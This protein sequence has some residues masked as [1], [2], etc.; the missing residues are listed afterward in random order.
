MLSLDEA[1]LDDVFQYWKPPVRR[2]PPLLW[3]RLRRD[4][5]DFVTESGSQ[6]IPVYRWMHQQF[7]ALVRERYLG[8]PVEPEGAPR[9]LPPDM[10]VLLADKTKRLELML[11]SSDQEAE[12]SGPSVTEEEIE[13]HS[14]CADYF[15]GKWSQTPK[16][17]KDG[18]KTVEA[19]RLVPRQPM[20]FSNRLHEESL[21][22]LE[23]NFRKLDELP[24]HLLHAKR[25]DVS[26]SPPSPLPL[27]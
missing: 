20:L 6:G 21:V 24:H 16:P 12:A 7:A 8:H 2:L 10:S 14:I 13:L 11:K 1:V 25:Q 23:P 17:Y 4:L 15:Q 5:G 26:S 18:K 22:W 9:H 27:P 3:V 19:D